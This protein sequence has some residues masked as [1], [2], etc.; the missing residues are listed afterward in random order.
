[1]KGEGKTTMT[2]RTGS[3]RGRAGKPRP[4]RYDLRLFVANDEPNSAIA[5]ASLEKI[6]SDYLAGNC[7]VEIVDVLKDFE[8]A[9]KE[10]ILVAPALIVQRGGR[11]DVIFG[12]LTDIDKV[13]TVLNLGSEK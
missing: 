6:C 11:R 13:R 1:M 12:N 10:N 3:R 8:P 4:E 9:L 7:M 5:R 2:A